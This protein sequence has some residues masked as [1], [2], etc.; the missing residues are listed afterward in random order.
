MNKFKKMND[1]LTTND[2]NE[3]ER[4]AFLGGAVISRLNLHVHNDIEEAAKFY[5]IPL[6]FYDWDDVYI[7]QEDRC[8]FVGSINNAK[9]WLKINEGKVCQ[10][11]FPLNDL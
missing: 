3:A 4:P 1:N 9:Q 5:K 7:L 10:S 11:R 8:V 6:C 2:Y